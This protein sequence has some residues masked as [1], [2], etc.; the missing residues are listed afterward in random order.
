M[1]KNTHSMLMEVLNSIKAAHNEI[2]CSNDIDPYG[3]LAD[4][5]QTM[6]DIGN[7][8]EKELQDDD[9]IHKIEKYC[10]A[11]FVA[12]NDLNDFTMSEAI[13][14]FG[15]IYDMVSN[16][17]VEYLIVFLPYKASMWDSME[18]IYYEAVKCDKCNCKVVPIPYYD[19]TE[20]GELCEFHYE[21]ESFAKRIPIVKWDEYDI[22]AEQ[23]DVVFIHNPYDAINSVTSIH[24][25]YYSDELKKYVGMLVYSPY[26]ISGTYKDEKAFANKVISPVMAYA[27]RIVVQ[28]KKQYELYEYMGIPKSHLW[29]C[30]S[31]KIDAYVNLSKEDITIPEFW[32]NKI[33]DKKVVVLNSSIGSLLKDTERYFY[34]LNRI[35]NVILDNKDIALIWRPHPLLKATIV[36]LRKEY[37]ES[38]NLII[39]KIID[40]GGIIDDNEDNRICAS[41][42]DAMISDMSSWARQYIVTG[43]PILSLTGKKNVYENSIKTF[44]ETGIYYWRSGVSVKS[45]CEMVVNGDDYEKEKRINKYMTSIVNPNG[46]AGKSVVIKM[47]E[48]LNA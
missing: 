20:N 42:S 4:C 5:Q 47:L 23:P 45:F 22:K 27:D 36:S 28:S 26:F 32:K 35:V 25:D 19:K 17:S 9:L 34:D 18:S 29:L 37:F 10:E 48:E 15:V 11:V 41:V 24:P 6:I 12:N 30:G 1:R 31:P 44:D 39:D 3:L 33:K 8:L 38:F 16:I 46:G 40:N 2:L 13:K 14:L 43:K 21:G 7:I